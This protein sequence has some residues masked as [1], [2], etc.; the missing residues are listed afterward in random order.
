MKNRF[1]WH[2]LKALHQIGF[3]KSKLL[4]KTSM[5]YKWIDHALRYVLNYY[6]TFEKLDIHENVRGFAR[7][8]QFNSIFVLITHTVNWYWRCLWNVI[9]VL[10]DCNVI[11]TECCKMQI[12][13]YFPYFFINYDDLHKL[14]KKS[15]GSIQKLWYQMKK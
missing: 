6:K 5:I 13:F 4:D 14:N 8:V 7:D 11:F 15:R 1:I 3:N 2:L 9:I 10:S 12:Y